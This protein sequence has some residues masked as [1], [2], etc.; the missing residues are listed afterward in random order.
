MS[1]SDSRMYREAAQAPSVVR[2]Q[3]ES[4]CGSDARASARCCGR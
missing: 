3:L 2:E 4:E 1:L